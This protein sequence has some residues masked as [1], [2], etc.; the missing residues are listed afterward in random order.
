MITCSWC[1][2]FLCYQSPALSLICC[3]LGQAKSGACY[4][5]TIPY[6]PNLILKQTAS[7]QTQQSC[8]QAKHALELL[9]SKAQQ[10]EAQHRAEVHATDERHH[11][12]V[13][14]RKK[15]IAHRN[16][17]PAKVQLQLPMLGLLMSQP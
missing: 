10:E 1:G 16:Q 5:T 7:T 15:R 9:G 11:S 3:S 12:P 6:L 8:L 2:I 13:R 14:V 17:K 4:S